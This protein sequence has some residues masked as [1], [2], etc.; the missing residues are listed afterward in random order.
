[1]VGRHY[2]TPDD[3]D[4]LRDDGISEASKAVHPTGNPISHSTQSGFSLPL[5]PCC[6]VNSVRFIPDERLP[7]HERGV[8]IRFVTTSLSGRLF[9]AIVSGLA[10]P[11]RQSRAEGVGSILTASHNSNPCL[12]L[13]L[14]PLIP[15]VGVG[16]NPDPIPPVRG[17]DG[18][19][20]KNHRP[21]GVAH[22]FQVR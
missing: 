8:G 12:L 20:R 14:P 21:D 11:L 10:L 19:S 18:A 16:H 5:I 7:L 4:D 15:L 22:A 6:V 3:L 17:A 2:R 9:R 1:M 13:P